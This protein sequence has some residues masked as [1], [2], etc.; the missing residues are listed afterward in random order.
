MNTSSNSDHS[1]NKLDLLVTGACGFI[2]SNFIKKIACRSEVTKQYN[3]HIVDA[4]TYAGFLGTI[5]P[6][7]N[8]Y[9]HLH[10]HQVDIRD[11]QKIS[12]LFEEHSFAGV[13][14]FAAESHVDRSIKNPNIF[15]ETNV[16]G[17]MNLL[18]A[19]LTYCQKN[20]NF[21]FFHVSTDE[22]YGS[23]NLEEDPFTE[24]TPLNP[25]GPYSA[26]KASSDLLVQSYFTTYGLPT[27]ISRCSNNYGPYQFPEKFIP[28][29][30]MKAL[31]DEPLPIYGKGEN[32]RDWIH[33]DD[34]NRGI[35]QAFQQGEPG[36]VYNFGGQAEKRNI[37]V[38]KMI[39]K[40]L[41]KSEDLLKSVLDRLG[42]DFRY[43]INF[44]KSEEKLNWKPEMSFEE[45]LKQTIDWYQNNLSW[46]K[47]VSSKDQ[48]K[49]TN[50]N[51]SAPNSMTSK[52]IL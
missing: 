5:R 12:E 16:L 21:R 10:F 31:K 7:L 22:V 3:F 35:W 49:Q 23:L 11:D 8:H 15:L 47:Q 25:S 29:M 36:E 44:S 32:V 37:D 34:H 33:V 41:G 48:A 14:H 6:E 51:I 50:K 9:P 27:I 2:G 52:N 38:A 4:L 39:L 42:H 43:A 30:I 17:T 26:S 18:N 40:E 20:K 28:V 1:K 24:K 19:S 46:I 13:I 45:G